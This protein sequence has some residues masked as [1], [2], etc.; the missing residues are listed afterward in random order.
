MHHIKLKGKVIILWLAANLDN[1]LYLS[2]KRTVVY[3]KN[4]QIIG[5]IIIIISV[6]IYACTYWKLRKQAKNITLQNSRESRAQ[7]I[8]ILKEKNFK[9]IFRQ[10]QNPTNIKH[11]FS[12]SWMKGCDW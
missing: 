5:A 4:N 3:R 6:V 11:T 9:Q 7:E 2:F 10:I 12:T 1:E 8:R